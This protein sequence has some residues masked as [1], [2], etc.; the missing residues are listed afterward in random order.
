LE[1]SDNKNGAANA[2]EEHGA[3]GP[4]SV[5]DGIYHQYGTKESSDNGN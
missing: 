2:H 5:L 1:C 4:F 3:K